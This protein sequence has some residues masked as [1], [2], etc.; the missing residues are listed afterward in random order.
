MKLSD[1]FASFLVFWLIAITFLETL[2]PII[3]LEAGF[4][5]EIAES[6]R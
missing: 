3:A 6:Y 2:E 4:V 1:I 5:T